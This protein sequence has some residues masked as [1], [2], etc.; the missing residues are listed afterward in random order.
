MQYQ[1]CFRSTPSSLKQVTLKTILSVWAPTG[2]LRAAYPDS[3]KWRVK[4]CNVCV[5]TSSHFVGGL[6]KRHCTISAV[7]TT[8]VTLMTPDVPTGSSSNPTNICQKTIYNDDQY[9]LEPN[10]V[11]ICC[12]LKPKA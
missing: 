1:C 7:V 10:L 11:F 6:F 8:G 9:I 5:F 4:F 12:R 2:K 3:S